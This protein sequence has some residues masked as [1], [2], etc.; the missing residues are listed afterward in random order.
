MA[1]QDL[2][3]LGLGGR[4]IGLEQLGQRHQHPRRAITAL[5]AVLVP[6]RLLQRRQ[7]IGRGEA[8]DGDNALAVGLRGEHQ[9][10]AH[11]LALDQHGAG[12][13]HTVLA[14]DMG[15]GE[16][17]LVAQEVGK[18]DARLD[19]AGVFGA[20]DVDL[21]IAFFHALYVHAL[22]RAPARPSAAASTRFDS[23]TARRW[24]YH[25]G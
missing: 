21:D 9:A 17:D 13:A 22:Y 18:I 4:G 12:A 15:A 16:A 14:A 11:R 23:A 5:Q 10:G 3:H 25:L 19:A 6:E 20:V 1:G 7:T 8:L 2:T 24:R